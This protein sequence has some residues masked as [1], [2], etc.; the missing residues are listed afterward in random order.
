MWWR[1]YI[2]SFPPLFIK[3]LQKPAIFITKRIF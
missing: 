1:A 2:K 3:N